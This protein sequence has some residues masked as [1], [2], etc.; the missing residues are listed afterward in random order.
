MFRNWPGMQTRAQPALR[1][2]RPGE[3]RIQ[4]SGEDLAGKLFEKFTDG[5][6][7]KFPEPKDVAVEIDGKKTS[8]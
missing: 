8:R 4:F 5:E 2:S 6:I 1:Q 7:S 3:L